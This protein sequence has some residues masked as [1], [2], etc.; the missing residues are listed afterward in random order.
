MRACTYKD[1]DYSHASVVCQNGRAWECRDGQWA[2][3]NRSCSAA[4]GEIIDAS[5]NRVP[6]QGRWVYVCSYK[7][8]EYRSESVI[9]QEGYE[10]KCWR[11]DWVALNRRSEKPDGKLDF[12]RTRELY[13][14]DPT[15]ERPA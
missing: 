12:E 13:G 6:S 9:C 3:L 15:K 4:D 5:G 10:F 8:T 1:F 7:G 11:G 14:Q 2:D